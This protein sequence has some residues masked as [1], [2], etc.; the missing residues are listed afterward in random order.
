MKM[1]VKWL[2]ALRKKK[3]WFQT[4]AHGKDTKLS[5]FVPVLRRLMF[6]F[7]GCSYWQEV[8]TDTLNHYHKII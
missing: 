8:Y 7:R 5:R 4:F 2:Q 6:V 1:P 3:P